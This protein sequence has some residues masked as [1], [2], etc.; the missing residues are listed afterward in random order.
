MVRSGCYW[1]CALALFSVGLSAIGIRWAVVE[2]W[3]ML[4]PVRVSLTGSP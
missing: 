1:G 4:E 2:A 3:E